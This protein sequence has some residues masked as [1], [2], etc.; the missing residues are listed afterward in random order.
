MK[1]TLYFYICFFMLGSCLPKPTIAQT[2]QFARYSNANNTFTNTSPI[3]T[4]DITSDFG[5]RNPGTQGTL[6]HR[7]VDIRPQGDQDFRLV[8]SSVPSHSAQ[9][10]GRRSVSD[11]R[12]T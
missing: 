12:P 7:G 9:A 6:F 2:L 4:G 1:K 8:R 3:L 5:P 11:L 10:H